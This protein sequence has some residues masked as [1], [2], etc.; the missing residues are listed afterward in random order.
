[1]RGAVVQGQGLADI[2]T[3]QMSC[4]CADWQLQ[5]LCNSAM[6]H[7]EQWTSIPQPP[8]LS[9]WNGDGRRAVEMPCSMSVLTLSDSVRLL[10]PSKEKPF[11]STAKNFRS[12]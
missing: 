1:M 6:V 12:Y 10:V 7:R 9:G 8:W 5:P 3:V 2:N 4:E 11:L